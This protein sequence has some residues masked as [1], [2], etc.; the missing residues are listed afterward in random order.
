MPPAHP[1][2]AARIAV[3]VDHFY[4]RVRADAV[5]GAVFNPVVHDWDAHQ[6]LLTSFW[7]SVLLRAGTYRGNPLA[8]HRA[9]AIGAAHFERWLALWNEVAC[10][11]LEPA[12]AATVVDYARR[13]GEGLR[14][15]LGIAPRET[16]ARQPLATIPCRTARGR[17]VRGALF[18]RRRRRARPLRSIR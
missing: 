6:R 8:M 18:S 13:I 3:L 16:P 15:G 2:H 12:Q 9:H 5:L 11:T 1:P 14:L 7:C 10:A 17:F 4:A